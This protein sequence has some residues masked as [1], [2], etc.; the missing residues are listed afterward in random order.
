M[1]IAGDNKSGREYGRFG[2]KQKEKFFRI[3]PHSAVV[4][5]TMGW[6][7][8]PG[9]TGYEKVFQYLFEPAFCRINKKW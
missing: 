2:F 3:S 1:H 6:K 9:I 5:N 8:F 7:I 4:F